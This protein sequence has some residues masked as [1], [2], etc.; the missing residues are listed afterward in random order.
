M[1]KFDYYKVLNF[2]DKIDRRN[3]LGLGTAVVRVTR[4]VLTNERAQLLIC[5]SRTIESTVLHSELNA[6]SSTL[7]SL[8]QTA[9]KL[10]KF[11]LHLFLIISQVIN[12]FH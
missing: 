3:S 12:T 9:V 2:G 10:S 7:L 6:K 4:Q 11:R 1:E 5:I 8:M